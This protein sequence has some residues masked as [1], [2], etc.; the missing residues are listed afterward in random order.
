MDH[1]LYENLKRWDHSNGEQNKGWDGAIYDY[2]GTAREIL[3]GNKIVC[4]LIV[5][6]VTW[7]HICGNIELYTEKSILLHV[8]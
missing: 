5:V 7:N 3:G 8:T 2:K 6:V 4:N 1:N